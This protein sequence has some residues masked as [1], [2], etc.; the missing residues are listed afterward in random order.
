MPKIDKLDFEDA[1]TCPNCGQFVGEES[2]CP[3]CG[4]VLFDENDDN[5]NE[6]DEDELDS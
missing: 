1:K 4:V 5:L 6:V 2:I 3:F